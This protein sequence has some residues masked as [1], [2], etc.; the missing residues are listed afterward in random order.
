M[1]A[2]GG[3]FWKDGKRPWRVSALSLGSAWLPPTRSINSNLIA[4]SHTEV[5]WAAEAASVAR[6]AVIVL[7]HYGRRSSGASQ[8]PLF[9]PA[10]QPAKTALCTQWHD[11]NSNVTSGIFA[12]PDST[13]HEIRNRASTAAEFRLSPTRSSPPRPSS[14]E[15]PSSAR[16]WWPPAPPP[17]GGSGQSWFLLPA[18]SAG[19]CRGAS[20]RPEPTSRL[21]RCQTKSGQRFSTL[22]RRPCRKRNIHWK[23]TI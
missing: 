21:R 16:P 22:T 12:R 9:N 20:R 3:G 17:S 1:R 18:P 10:T 11:F 14:A 5:L 19:R 15:C 23:K 6:Q 7:F 2:E 8:R 13:A 4:T